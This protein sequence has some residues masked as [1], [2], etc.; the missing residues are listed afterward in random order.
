MHMA[1]KT[2]FNIGTG[3]IETKLEGFITFNE[4]KEVISKSTILA[5]ENN[6]YLWLTDYGETTPSLSTMEIYSLPKLFSEAATSL[7]ISVFHIKRA[8]V[9]S[10]SKADFP[11]AKTIALNRG[12]SLDLFDDI[13]TAR[14]WLKNK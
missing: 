5:K 9:I 6:C 2:I 8:I 1:H 3:I 10:K 12:Q 7:N 4:V 11:F 13:E 14:N